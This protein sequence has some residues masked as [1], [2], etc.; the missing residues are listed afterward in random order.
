MTSAT[1]K[2]IRNAKGNDA[3][4]WQLFDGDIAN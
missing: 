3:N 1:A 4:Q 2:S